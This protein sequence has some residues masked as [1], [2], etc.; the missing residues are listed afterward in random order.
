MLNAFEIKSPNTKFNSEIAYIFFQC[1]SGM[2]I[3]L[4]L[5]VVSP[6]LIT[7]SKNYQIRQHCHFGI[8]NCS[9][10]ARNLANR[11]GALAGLD[12]KKYN[13]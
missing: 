12:E 11:A 1:S 9:S 6:F 2:Y 10:N 4:F 8:C 13:T 5:R 3:Y 7:N